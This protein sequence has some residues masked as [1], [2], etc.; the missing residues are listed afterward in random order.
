MTVTG[1]LPT[2]DKNL[3]PAVTV[4]ST[5]KKKLTITTKDNE[6]S[7]DTAT[8][9]I[10]IQASLY[11]GGIVGYCEKDSDL[12]I[13]D[14][15]NKGSLSLVF[16]ST[17]DVKLADFIH[18]QEVGRNN[19]PSDTEKIELHFVGGVIGVNLENQVVDHCAN[20]GTMSGFAGIG[21]I[22]GLNS[23]LI[24]NCSLNDN[25]GNAGLS[26]LGGIASVNIRSND[27]DERTY[28]TSVTYHTGTIEKCST[29]KNKTVSGKATIGGIVAWNMLDGTLKQNSS[30]ANI[31]GT[32]NYVGGV[33][34]RN[35]GSIEIKDE[36]NY[37]VTRTIR[38]N[39][40]SGIGGV[41]GLNEAG[42]TILIN[43][44]PNAKGEL[45]AVGTGVTVIGYERVGGIVGINQ[46]SLG[47]EGDGPKLASDAK[48]IRASHGY[49][50]GV[51]GTT[52]P[53]I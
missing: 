40:G 25:F 22:V 1:S 6:K 37:S 26:Y 16:G 23:G 11:A 52:M 39:N 33:A 19:L 53:I 9:N 4:K 10:P 8:N 31:T 47:T 44:T 41:V 29:A 13:K 3:V 48:Q 35:S 14:C 46:G 2:L 21:G 15:W 7:F 49:A 36:S 34:G 27:T 5:N 28:G 45:T 51:V 43:G 30:L 38:S 42:G 20:T 32:G 50:G 18:S 24:Y 12:V 17:D